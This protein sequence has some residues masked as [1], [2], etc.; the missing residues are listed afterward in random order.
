M[1]VCIVGAIQ[2]FKSCDQ[3]HVCKIEKID[4]ETVQRFRI[5]IWIE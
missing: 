5:F 3:N 4:L 1:L 2:N